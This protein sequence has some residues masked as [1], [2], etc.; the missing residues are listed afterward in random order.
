MI[1]RCA[2]V[3]NVVGEGEISSSPQLSRESSREFGRL[4]VGRK[5]AV[6]MESPIS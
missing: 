6:E 4:L 2:N 3:G 5:T 1:V